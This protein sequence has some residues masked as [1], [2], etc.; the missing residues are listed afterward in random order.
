MPDVDTRI[1]DY[2]LI[3]N[4]ETPLGISAARLLDIEYKIVIAPVIH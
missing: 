4:S 2:A 3:E 1:G